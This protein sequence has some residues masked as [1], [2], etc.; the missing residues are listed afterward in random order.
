MNII[1][2]LETNGLLYECTKIHCAVVRKSET[3]YRLFKDPKTEDDNILDYFQELKGRLDFT[4][5]GHNIFGFDNEVLKKL[6]NIDLTKTN[7]VIDTYIMSQVLFGDL[8]KRDF[9]DPKLPKQFVGKHSLEAWGHRLGVYKGEYTGGFE[10]YNDE[11]GEYC[12]Q[13]TLVT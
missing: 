2:D 8:A 9:G 13:D 1:L 11:M 3:E 12:I 10:E 6:Y 5:I 4:F 7:K